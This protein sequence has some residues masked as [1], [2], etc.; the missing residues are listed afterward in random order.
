MI[1]I[2]CEKWTHLQY[3]K[4]LTDIKNKIQLPKGKGGEGPIERF[5]TDNS[6]VKNLSANAGDAGSISRSGRSLGAINGHPLQYSCLGNPVDRG[7]WWATVHRVAKRLNW[8]CTHRRLISVDAA[9]FADLYLSSGSNYWHWALSLHLG[10]NPF[11]TGTTA[12]LWYFQHLIKCLVLYCCC[13]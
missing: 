2:I 8:A 5:V 9:S 11:G 12:F 1:E 13:C 6:A 4:T 7:T 3:R 10:Y